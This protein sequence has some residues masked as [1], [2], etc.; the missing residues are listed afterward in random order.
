MINLVI[1]L[2]TTTQLLH[3]KHFP[4]SSDALLF[5]LRARISAKLVFFLIIVFALTDAFRVETLF[6]HE[7]VLVAKLL[8][9]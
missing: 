6:F 7:R 5:P 3:S 2:D 9:H 1:V 4:P 8:R